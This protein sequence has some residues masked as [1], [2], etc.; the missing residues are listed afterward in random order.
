LPKTAAFDAAGAAARFAGDLMG[1]R[2][3]PGR[4]LRNPLHLIWR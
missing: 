1:R 3:S 4:L 2:I